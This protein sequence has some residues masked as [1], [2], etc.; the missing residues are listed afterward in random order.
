MQ[1]QASPYVGEERVRERMPALA[2]TILLHT[3]ARHGPVGRNIC[4]EQRQ[5]LA[6]IG[7]DHLRA[8]QRG[9]DAYN[10]CTFVSCR[11]QMLG[12]PNLFQHQVR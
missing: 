1:Q 4:V 5:N 9:S 11:K 2:P 8:E 3:A 10:P 7:K 6:L 12:A